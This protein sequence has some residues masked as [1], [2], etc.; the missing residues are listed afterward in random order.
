MVLGGQR[1]EGAAGNPWCPGLRDRISKR[2]PAAV[3]GSRRGRVHPGRVFSLCFSSRR[4]ESSILE[5][6]RDIAMV[7]RPG[8][9][10]PLW[11]EREEKLWLPVP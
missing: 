7:G 9:S 3:L 8:G 10:L 6:V 5:N 2:A 11:R 1:P 4:S